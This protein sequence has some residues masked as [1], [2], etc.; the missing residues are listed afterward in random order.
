MLI[1]HLNCRHQLLLSNHHFLVVFIFHLPRL[2]FRLN[3][4]FRHQA[5]LTFKSNIL[6]ELRSLVELCFQKTGLIREN[7]FSGYVQISFFNKVARDSIFSILFGS[8]HD[9]SG[10]IETPLHPPTYRLT[11]LFFLILVHFGEKEISDCKPT[12]APEVEHLA[13]DIVNQ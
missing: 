6:G 8:N 10:L 4:P 1:S 5:T 12:P 7:Y 13:P 3:Q 9:C 2:F 11:E